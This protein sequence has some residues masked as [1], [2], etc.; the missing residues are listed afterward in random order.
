MAINTT[1]PPFRTYRASSRTLPGF[2]ILPSD[3]TMKFERPLPRENIQTLSP[4]IFLR[5][6]DA[7]K[8]T[9]NLLPIW[10]PTENFKTKFTIKISHLIFLH[11]FLLFFCTKQKSQWSADHS[12]RS[13]RQSSQ[14]WMEATDEIPKREASIRNY[15]HWSSAAFKNNI[16]SSLSLNSHRFSTCDLLDFSALSTYFCIVLWLEVSSNL[17]SRRI[18]LMMM[19]WQL[20]QLKK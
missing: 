12:V 7:T 15:E 17:T 2:N 20:L 5:F 13:L 18:C 10:D 9:R 19:T 4:A 1:N 8:I 16:H 6:L 14:D 3:A 11:F